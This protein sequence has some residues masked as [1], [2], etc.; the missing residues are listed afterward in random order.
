MCWHKWTK[1]Q[2]VFT[3]RTT[4]VGL[5]ESVLPKDTSAPPASPNGDLWIEQKRVC[6]KCGQIRLRT[7]MA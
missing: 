2:E 5:I 4:R 6:E 7:E 1:W 3:G